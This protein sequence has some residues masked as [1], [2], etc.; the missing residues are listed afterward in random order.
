MLLDC[1]D[2]EAKGIQ[3][4]GDG[5][6]F[7]PVNEPIH[8]LHAKSGVDQTHDSSALQEQVVPKSLSIGVVVV[9]GGSDKPPIVKAFTRRHD[10]Y[11][12]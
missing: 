12:N 3:G 10:W 6:I 9:A 1:M 5:S 7:T 11:W 4:P 8:D 2:M